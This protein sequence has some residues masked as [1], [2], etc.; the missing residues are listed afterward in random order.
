MKI[1]IVPEQIDQEEK[2]GKDCNLWRDNAE[3]CA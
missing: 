1:W 3:A 2:N